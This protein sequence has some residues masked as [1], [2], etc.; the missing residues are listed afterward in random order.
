MATPW[1]P[2]FSHCSMARSAW[3][4]PFG[5]SGLSGLPEEPRIAGN[6]SHVMARAMN[7][8]SADSE[9]SARGVCARSS[10]QQAGE[11]AMRECQ[12]QAITGPPAAHTASACS[13]PC[14]RQRMVRSTTRR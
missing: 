10:G 6:P 4:P 8:P 9:I 12:K 2:P 1:F 5:L 7:S 13:R 14:H 3:A 11:R